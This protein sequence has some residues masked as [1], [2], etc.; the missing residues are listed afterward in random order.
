MTLISSKVRQSLRWETIGMKL[1]ILL[2]NGLKKC[3]LYLF[4]AH[5]I[6]SAHIFFIKKIGDHGTK[7]TNNGF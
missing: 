7:F 6:E 4:D 2:N 1:R 3:E 5:Y